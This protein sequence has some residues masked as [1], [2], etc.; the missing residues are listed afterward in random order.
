MSSR[1]FWRNE[2]DKIRNDRSA[3]EDGPFT[4]EYLKSVTWVYESNSK[5]EVTCIKFEK[6]IFFLRI[7]LDKSAKGK[8][9]D[10]KILDSNTYVS[11][12]EIKNSSIYVN[13]YSLVWFAKVELNVN[14]FIKTGQDDVAKYIAKLE[15][16]NGKFSF[17]DKLTSNGLICHAVI[18]IPDVMK[19]MGWEYS[20]KSQVDWFKGKA[21]NYPWESEPKVNDIDIDWALGFNKFRKICDE[22]ISEYKILDDVKARKSLNNEIKK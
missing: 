4:N 8:N 3:V 14:D 18:Y 11:S 15:I 13:S 9:I 21:N 1:S 2:A 16:D 20:Y 5:K 10:I 12:T 19:A 22:Y 6:T 17:N 7:E